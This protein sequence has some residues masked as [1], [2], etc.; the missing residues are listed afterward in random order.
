[1]PTAIAV[2]KLAPGDHG[3]HGYR[4]TVFHEMH[5]CERQD[6]AQVMPVPQQTGKPVVVK[7]PVEAQLRA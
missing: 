4:V 3:E 5:N 2:V 6:T 7:G 1:V